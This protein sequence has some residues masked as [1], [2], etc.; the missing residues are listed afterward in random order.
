[1]IIYW[2]VDIRG[3]K[4]NRVSWE[5]AMSKYCNFMQQVLL[6]VNQTMNEQLMLDFMEISYLSEC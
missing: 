3:K 2:R 5:W 4:S 1:M 6:G